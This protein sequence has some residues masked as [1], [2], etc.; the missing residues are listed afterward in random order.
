MSILRIVNA[1]NRSLVPHQ[2][3]V[4]TSAVLGV[5][6]IEVQKQDDTVVIQAV[7]SESPRQA[8]LLKEA[9][10]PKFCPE[11]SLGLDVK[12]TDVLILSQ[13]VRNDGCMLPRRITG[14]CKRQQKK[15]GTLVTM[16]QKAGLMPNLGPS[17]SKKDPK[18]RFGWRKY[19]KYYYESSIKY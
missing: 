12:H 4:A 7:T 3:T 10:Q 13:Y 15:M 19:N 11:C 18:Q 16:A 17:S 8:L 9:C 1:F 6:Q 5:K 14:L 2:R